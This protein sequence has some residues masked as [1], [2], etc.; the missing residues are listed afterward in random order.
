MGMPGRTAIVAVG[1]NSMII[2]D[3]HQ[4]I[5]DQYL[6]AA[7]SSRYVADM[8]EA[9]VTVVLTHGN[10]PQVGFILRRSGIAKDIVPEV[11]IDYA[12]ADTQG[13]I[14]YMFQRALYNEFKR[15]GLRRNVIAV[16]TQVLVDRGDP[17]LSNPT[18]PIG[19]YFDAVTAQRLA[20][21]LGWAVKEDAGRGW[22]RVVGSPKPKRIIELDMIKS[23]ISQGHIVIAC[24]GG[25]IPV[26]ENAEGE[27]VGLE[28]V[29]DKDFASALL[30]HDLDADLLVISTGVEKVAINFNEPNQQWLERLTLA[31]A[32]R[33]LREGQFP[34]GSMGPKV[35]AI[36]SFLE[37]DGDRR[38]IITNPPN[39]GRALE[40]LAGTHITSAHDRAHGER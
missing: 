35:E 10:G 33:L 27:L 21:E 16:V 9:G 2:D 26:V 19:S 1:G 20:A 8:V 37:P 32:K 38:A 31:D 36:V 14:G 3:R 7:Q 28:A 5:P 15:R 29:I 40:G 6:A 24:G 34:S 22:R 11:P 39:L 30:A 17:A 4:S 12:S 25:G 18:K 13:A 23:L